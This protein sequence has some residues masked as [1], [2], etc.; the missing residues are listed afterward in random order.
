MV[1]YSI[2][3]VVGEGGRFE[4]F[5]FCD[6]NWNWDYLIRYSNLIRCS[7]LIMTVIEA[8]FALSTLDLCNVRRIRLTILSF[9]LR[10]FHRGVRCL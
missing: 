1:V 4:L 9:G 6:C 10:T 2:T 5:W 7:E 3:G 8:D